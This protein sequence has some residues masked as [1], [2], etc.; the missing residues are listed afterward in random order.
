[1]QSLKAAIRNFFLLPEKE[2]NDSRRLHFVDGFRALALLLMVST[3]G[4]KAWIEPSLWTGTPLLLKNYATRIPG[5]VFFFLVGVSYIMARDA[6]LRKG[7]SDKGVLLS[8]FKRSLQLLIFAYL[9]KA[10]DLIFGVPWKYIN[11]WLVDVL[12]IIAVSLAGIALLD[13]LRKR[14]GLS[15]TFW[16]LAAIAA[17]AVEPFVFWLH[18][19]AWFP[20]QI[21]WYL[22]GV[23]PNA[24]FTLFPYMGLAVFGSAAGEILTK[25]EFDR[26]FL[27]LS[28]LALYPIAAA[29]FFQLFA[30]VSP[31]DQLKIERIAYF[32]KGLVLLLIGLWVS[33]HFQKKIGFGPLLILGSYTMIG[34]WF[35]AKWEFVYYQKALFK[36]DWSGAGWLLL[37]TYITTIIVVLAYAKIKRQI[38]KRKKR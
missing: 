30:L 7:L 27:G 32:M 1:M 14:L 24:Y 19:P 22:Q 9:Y 16:P 33:Y 12:N 18:F 34:Y 4:F 15:N 10:I 8:F 23:S 29:I 31:F 13:F 37:K 3:H 11:I 38:I 25:R 2:I 26:P 35:H 21:L 28:K 20:D 17:V 36:M 6:K 5:A